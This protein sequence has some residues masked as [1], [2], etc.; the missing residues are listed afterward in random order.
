[1]LYI[2]CFF[3]CAKSQVVI[4]IIAEGAFFHFDLN[5]NKINKITA[6]DNRE[7]FG[8]NDSTWPG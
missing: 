5:R 6:F 7:I 4:I 1:M 8:L 3:N 2:K